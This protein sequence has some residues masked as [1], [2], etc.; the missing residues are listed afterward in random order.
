MRQARTTPRYIDGTG[1]IQTPRSIRATTNNVTV[2]IVL[3]VVLPATFGAD[4]VCATFA[5]R[6]MAAAWTGVVAVS[7]VGS[8]VH[9]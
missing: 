7:P 4:L 3:A 5:E 8:N 1:V 2:V 6:H 9:L